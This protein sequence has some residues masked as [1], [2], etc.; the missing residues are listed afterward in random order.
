MIRY[1]IYLLNDDVASHY[2]HRAEKIVE[3][4]REHQYAKA[5][6]KAICR[7]QVEFITERLSFSRLELG[8]K[9]YFAGRVGKNLERNMFVLQNDAGEEALLVVQKRRLLLVADSAPL[10]ADIGQ[11]LARLSPT[12]LAVDADFAD[13]CWLSA[14][15]QGRKFA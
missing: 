8:L 5:P 13:Y 1:W 7:K 15:R 11:A 4:L 14:P 10:A 12:F 2:R 3:L 9:Q 6:L